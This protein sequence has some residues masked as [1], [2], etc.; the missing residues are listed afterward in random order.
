MLNWYGSET[1]TFRATDPGGLW[2]DDPATFT[3]TVDNAPPNTPS[4]PSPVNGASGVSVTVDLGWAGGDPDVGDAVL[5]DVYFGTSGSPLIVSQNQSDLRYD[6][7]TLGY[8]TTYYWKIVPWDNHN[9]STIGP[10][11]HFTTAPPSGSG[12]GGGGGGGGV[13]EPPASQP[14]KAPVANA[15]A[16]EPYQG[17]VS[18]GIL[19]DGSRSYDPDGNITTWSWGFGDTMNETGK[20][21]TYTFSQTG[22]YNVTLIV[23]DDDG[24]TNTDTTTCTITQP[25]RPP[26]QPIITGPTNGTRNI[27]YMYSA[28]STDADNDTV[29]YTFDWG[30]SVI[31]PSRFLP[32]ST[33]YTVNHSWTVAG[34]YRITV[35]ATDNHT[36]S[37]SEL[38]VYIDALQ[39]NGIGYLLDNNSDGVYD[40]FYSDVSQQT[41]S[42]QKEGDSFPIDSDGDG[43]WEYTY[44]ATNG[45]AAYKAPTGTYGFE[46]IVALIAIALYLF[47]RR[48]PK[49]ET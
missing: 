40:A 28:L 7:G 13:E 43:D 11:W 6:L 1:I 16:G 24:A 15:S 19:F 21:V 44:T 32:C 3:V 33:S 38:I 22:T 20:T 42:I 37:S 39:A 2:D 5:Y 41:L 10:V 18:S 30:D 29:Q 46:I 48:K 47:W 49:K 27:L 12:G 9:I 4:T 25:N 45:F 26:T 31:Q 35:I 34:R 14:N 23:T 36:V 17:F 8:S